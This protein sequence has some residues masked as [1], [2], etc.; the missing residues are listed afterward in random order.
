M[1]KSRSFW[2]WLFGNSCCASREKDKDYT[3]KERQEGKDRA[4][5]KDKNLTTSKKLEHEF[6]DQPGSIFREVDLNE[7]SEYP[8]AAGLTGEYDDGSV[9]IR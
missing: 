4:G 3:G 9:E 2:D 8:T 6:D 7:D 1:S 5:D